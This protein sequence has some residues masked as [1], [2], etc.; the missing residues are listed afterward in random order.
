MRCRS[1]GVTSNMAIINHTHG[2]IF[3]HIPK[4]AGTSITSALSEYTRYCDLEIGGTAFGEA[5]APAYLERFRLRK[6]SRAWQLRRIVGREAWDS[7]FTF[8]FVRDPYRRS[9]SIY[10]F[11]REWRGPGNNLYDAVHAYADFDAFVRSG[12]IF[13]TD[14]PDGIFCPQADWLT[15][16]DQPDDLLVDFV[17]RVESVDEDLEKVCRRLGL[18]TEGQPLSQRNRSAASRGGSDLTEET[19][20]MLRERYRRDFDLFGYPE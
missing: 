4:A 12:L 5:I 2:F 20:A 11:L 18:A 1:Y 10:H 6:H 14:G 13:E 16:D 3:V 15:A 9:L 8:S 17:G 7:A 19:K